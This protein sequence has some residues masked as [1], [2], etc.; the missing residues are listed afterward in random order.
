MIPGFFCRV[1]VA[2]GKNTVPRDASLPSSQEVADRYVRWNDMQNG[3]GK[4][5][6]QTIR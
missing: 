4:T 5:A 1:T 6:Q 3:F 2:G